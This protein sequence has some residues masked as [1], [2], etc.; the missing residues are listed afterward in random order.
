L[1][2]GGAKKEPKAQIATGS[3]GRSTIEAIYEVRLK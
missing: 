3:G 1:R 2:V